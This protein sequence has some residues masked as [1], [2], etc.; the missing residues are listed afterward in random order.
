MPCHQYGL[1]ML[2]SGLDSKQIAEETTGMNASCDDI[3]QQEL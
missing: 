2:A 1:A 3:M